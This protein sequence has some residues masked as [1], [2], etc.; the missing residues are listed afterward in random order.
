MRHRSGEGTW[1]FDRGDCESQREDMHNCRLQNHDNWQTG[2][3]QQLNILIIRV[4]YS[5][6]QFRQSNRPTRRTPAR[7]RTTPDTIGDKSSHPPSDTSPLDGDAIH[8]VDRD[9]PPVPHHLHHL[10][11]DER[12][13]LGDVQPQPPREA[14]LRE[15]PRR[16]EVEVIRLAGREVERPPDDRRRRQP[17]RRRRRTVAT[18]M[19][20]GVASVAVD[21]DGRRRARCSHG[22]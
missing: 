2:K 8:A 20:G 7:T 22:R 10:R 18:T 16:V 19:G 12:P 14:V 11:G 5:Q 21:G 4:G 3:M 17:R 9:G 15:P 13:R 6:C 1:H